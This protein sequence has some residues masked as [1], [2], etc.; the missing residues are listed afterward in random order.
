ML[1]LKKNVSIL[2]I[3][4][5]IFVFAACNKNSSTT[6]DLTT[7]SNLTNIVTTVEDV[8]TT[9]ISTEITYG[10]PQ[11]NL[12]FYMRDADVIQEEDGLRYVVYTTNME[13][14]VDINQ[15]AI[16][17]GTDNGEGYIYGDEVVIL[18]GDVNG[19]DSYIGSASITKGSFSFA[20]FTYS[21][22]MAYSGTESST[23]DAFSIGFA[24]ANDP[25]GT[26][27]KVGNE[28][29]VSYDKE[30]YGEAYAGFY[31]PSLINMN[32]DSIVRLFYTWGDA[33]GHFTYFI[34]FDLANLDNLVMS[35]YAMVPNNGN[36]SSGDDATLMPNTDMVYDSVEGIFYMVKDYSPSASQEPKVSTRI[37]IAWID[38]SEL[39][40]VPNE[41]GWTSLEVYDFSDTPDYLFERLYS[42]SIVSDAYGHLLSTETLEIVYNVSDLQIENSD[43]LY[44]QYLEVFYYQLED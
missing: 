1:R 20:G 11:P 32:K 29:I 39:Y 43:Y 21:Y 13:S 18:E 6:E 44:S 15:I 41:N 7:S 4:M 19:W 12:G 42:G 8:T 31:A 22:L 14:G 2:L 33:Y 35:G 38:E 24:L 27:V 5:L 36:L 26:W 37:E 40:V 28:P 23:D 9:E 10:I 34:D 25:L 30:V 3:F 17:Q 16:R